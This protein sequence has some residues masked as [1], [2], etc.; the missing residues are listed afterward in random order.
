MTRSMFF[1]NWDLARRIEAAKAK[2]ERVVDHLLYLI[3][4]QANNAFIVYS[5]LISKQVPKSFA[6]HAFNVFQR[7]MHQYE[8]IRLCA[9][10]DG[11]NEHR[12]NIPT[13]V[14]LVSDDDIIEMLAEETRMH[15]DTPPNPEY[16]PTEQR[17]L[18]EIDR[19]F[20][21]QQAPRY[22]VRTD[23]RATIAEADAIWGSR[24]LDALLNARHKHLAH[25]LSSTKRE[26][27]QH[28]PVDP[29]RYGDETDL[30]NRSIPIVETLYRC[31]SGVGFSV[32][33]SREHY[34]RTA[35]SLWG[36][37]KFDVLD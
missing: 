28:D 14:A 35:K 15:W 19:Q 6:A 22:G 26:N 5:P 31:V 4:I 8:I 13:V 1:N 37:C 32:D 25:N 36:G 17:Q 33:P 3:D 34:Q 12:E 21:L 11:I 27:K 2:M 7:S 29:I 24:Q 10:W 30:A 20:G 16:A 9:L 18:A 23:L